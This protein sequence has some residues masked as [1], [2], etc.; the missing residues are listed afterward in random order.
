[1]T[2]HPKSPGELM[3]D[4]PDRESPP[5]T[6]MPPRIVVAPICNISCNVHYS[7]GNALLFDTY[8]TRQRLSLSQIAL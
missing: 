6:L 2:S 4:L 1:M 8:V 5:T 7:I 3:E